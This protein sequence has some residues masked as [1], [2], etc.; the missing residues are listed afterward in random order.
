MGSVRKRTASKEIQRFLSRVQGHFSL[1]N[2]SSWMTSPTPNRRSCLS[3]A[4]NQ[5]MP[6]GVLTTVCFKRR[7]TITTKTNKTQKCL[8]T[9]NLQNKYGHSSTVSRCKHLVS[10]FGKTCSK[11]RRERK[12]KREKSARGGADNMESGERENL[13]CG[14]L[15]KHPLVSRGLGANYMH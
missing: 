5:K 13:G 3:I 7:P 2:R 14:S 6:F 11:A 15:L 1:W 8:Q 10:I 4:S 9:F 12:T